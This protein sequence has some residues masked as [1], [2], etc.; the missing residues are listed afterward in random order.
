MKRTIFSL[1]FFALLLG[2]VASLGA[3]TASQKPQKPTA[4]PEPTR[5]VKPESEWRKLLTSQQYYVLRQK[6]T[7]R[8]F[9]SRLNNN[10][11]TG[12]FVCAGC[13]WSLFASES[14]FDS[15]TGWPSFYKPLRKGAVIEKTDPDGERS[16]VLCAR[17]DGHLGHVFNDAT[18]EYGIPKTPTGLRY[19]MNGVSLAFVPKKTEKPATSA[20]GNR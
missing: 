8:A 17:C 20:S 3:Q 2:I 4:T 11:D 19:C 10:H 12:T 6:G 16:E 7:E 1:V 15:G 13:K 18:G 5:I 9:S 14:K